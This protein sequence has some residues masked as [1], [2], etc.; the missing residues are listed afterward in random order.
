MRNHQL[1]VK[2][3]GSSLVYFLPYYFLFDTMKGR[4]PGEVTTHLLRDA[5]WLVS[6]RLL[7][8][9]V[10]YQL[11]SQIVSQI[12]RERESSQYYQISA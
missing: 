12:R 2:Y 3:F 10:S 4:T 7:L 5:P 11:H 6:A 1:K 8:S 9:S